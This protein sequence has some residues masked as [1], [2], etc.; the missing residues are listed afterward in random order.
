MVEAGLLQRFREGAQ[1]YYRLAEIGESATLARSLVDLL[2]TNDSELNRDLAGLDAI[3][4]RRATLADAYFN[5]NAARWD[6]I[7]QLHVAEADVEQRLL[8]VV[9]RQ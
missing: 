3:W 5:E 6:E 7:R 1:V 4:R 2:P 9:G 8:D